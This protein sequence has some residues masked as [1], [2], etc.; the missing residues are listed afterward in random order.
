MKTMEDA[1]QVL[2]KLGSGSSF[3]S[4]A[5][6]FSICPSGA[7]GGS[8]GSFSPGTMVSEFDRVIFSPDT[9]LGEVVGPVQTKVR[10]V[11]LERHL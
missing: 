7:Q 6:E 9:N 8:L 3:A 4:L 2:E 11:S 10:L 1:D 5:S